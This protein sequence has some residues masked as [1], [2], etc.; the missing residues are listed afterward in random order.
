MSQHWALDFGLAFLTMSLMAGCTEK[1]VEKIE[2]GHDYCDHCKM[3][4]TDAR[5]GGA[6]VTKYGKTLKYDSMECLAHGQH[7]HQKEVEEIFVADFESEDLKPLK[8][9]KLY[10]NEEARGPMGTKIQ[11]LTKPKA[12][13][14]VELKDIPL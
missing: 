2:V 8:A 7:T 1:T 14:Q 5:Y 4:I 6:I 11:G 3:Q 10:R 9:I 12:L 13:P